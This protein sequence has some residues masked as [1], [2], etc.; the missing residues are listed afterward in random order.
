MECEEFG[1]FKHSIAECLVSREKFSEARKIMETFLKKKIPAEEIIFLSF[2]HYD[3]KRVKM[4][5][6][7]VLKALKY[8]FSHR[9]SDCEKMF[10]FLK[11]E[12]YYHQMLERG[13]VLKK[14]ILEMLEVLENWNS[15]F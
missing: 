4:G 9:D 10:N 3:D 5:T 14:Y 15:E 2:R 1:D 13:F 6:W 12:L 8:I 7:F 11:Q